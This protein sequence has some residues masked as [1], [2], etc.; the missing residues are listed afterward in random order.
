MKEFFKFG[1][2]LGNKTNNF[3]GI[4]GAL[5]ILVLWYLLTLSGNLIPAKI[6]PSPIL[7][8]QQ[9]GS[10][11]T[12]YGLLTEAWYSIK[13]N[14]YGYFFGIALAVPLG[15]FLG[16]YAL[17]KGLFVRYT[18]AL[19]YLPP[20]S[21]AGIFTAILGYGFGMKATFLAFAIFVS[22]LPCVIQKI[23]DLQNPKNDK[24]FVYLQTIKT[25]GANNFQKLTKVYIPYVMGRLWDDIV[26][27]T[28]IT[29]TYIIIVELL[30]REGGL[31]GL[32]HILRRQGLMPEMCGVLFCIVLIGIFQDF[33]LKQT[34]KVIFPYKYTEMSVF[35]K[36]SMKTKKIFKHG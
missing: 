21:I 32:I 25:L 28:A 27:L 26:N 33:L 31:G 29:W 24:D 30:N 14:L 15:F 3:L 18:D 10:L 35:K 17:P 4:I 5:I 16:I 7:V 8:F 34:G 2:T 9:F 6:L 12:E 13:L 19:R 11:F 22:L 23:N 1:G 36:M 20:P